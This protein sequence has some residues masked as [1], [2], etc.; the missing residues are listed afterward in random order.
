MIVI[1]LLRPAFWRNIRSVGIAPLL[2]VR[3]LPSICSEQHNGE[4][5]HSPHTLMSAYAAL[6]AYALRGV[7]GC[8]GHHHTRDAVL[9]HW[10]SPLGI[11]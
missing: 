7:G 9:S 11:E 2:V 4:A 6:S 5:R 3:G 10:R 1:V 8:N